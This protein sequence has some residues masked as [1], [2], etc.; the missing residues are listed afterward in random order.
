MPNYR[1]PTGLAD[2]TE[3]QDVDYNVFQVF[4]RTPA[5]QAHDIYLSHELVEPAEYDELC[6]LLR[7]ASPQDV[8][9][10]Y[11]NTDGGELA[12]GLAIIQ[13][14]RESPATIVTVLN[15]KAFSM[16]ALIYL[17]GDVLE[18]RPN[19]LLMFHTY[20]SGLMGKGN[21]QAAEVAA[22]NAWYEQVLKNTSAH[23]LSKSEIKAVLQ[24][25]DL[26][27]HYKDIK[28]RLKAM[29]TERKARLNSGESSIQ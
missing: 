4:K 20:S 5:G 13:A 18:V 8:I 28:R 16:G 17:S 21:E 27:L 14:M 9:R 7:T 29:K 1:T 23:F 26:W 24:G 25:K 2:E 11:L 12:S 3:D 19:S 15:P 6:Q 10:M 22:L